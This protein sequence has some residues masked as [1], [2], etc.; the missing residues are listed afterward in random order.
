[1]WRARGSRADDASTSIGPEQPGKPIFGPANN[2][3]G[4]DSRAVK[5]TTAC[6]GSR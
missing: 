2:F 3:R 4:Y 1:M 6:K 5:G